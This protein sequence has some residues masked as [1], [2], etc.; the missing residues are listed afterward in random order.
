MMARLRT[1]FC[2]IAATYRLT[3]WITRRFARFAK[4]GSLR[5]DIPGF[6]QVQFLQELAQNFIIN[7]STIPK[8]NRRLSLH[9]QQFKR[10]RQEFGVGLRIGTILA[11]SLAR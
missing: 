9:T 3:R 1:D 10:N 2:S 7:A 5:G 8:T 4:S 11:L 6:T